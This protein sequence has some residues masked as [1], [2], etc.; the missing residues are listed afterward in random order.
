MITTFLGG[1][2]MAAAMIGGSLQAGFRS[3]DLRVCEPD[4][5]RAE[6][7]EREFG[8]RTH[9]EAGEWIAGSDLVVLAV[10]PQDARV[11][12]EAARPHVGKTL[13][14]SIAAGVRAAT[15][16]RWLG[17]HNIVRAMP[18]TPAL[19]GSGITGVV[20]LPTVSDAARASAQRMLEAVGEVVWLDDETL[21]DPV[22][23]LSGSGPAYVFYFAEAIQRAGCDLGLSAEQ[24]RQLVMQTFAG[25]VRLAI[26]SGEPL[27]RLRERVTSKGGTTAAALA[28]L[29][30]DRVG[31]AIARAVLAANARA[32]AMGDELDV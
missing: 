23:A 15:L 11:A 25:A 14:L 8:V 26:D 10:K 7:L 1:G 12:I 29:E 18:N 21:L 32:K 27:A 20:A 9:R 16:A 13:L 3:E 19:V 28:S 24:A 6:H 5:A 31:A 22:T 4:R 2:N 17:H 30:S